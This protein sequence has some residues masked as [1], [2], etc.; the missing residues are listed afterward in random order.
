[1]AVTVSPPMGGKVEGPAAEALAGN[2]GPKKNSGSPATLGNTRT[3]ESGS[4]ISDFFKII[5]DLFA[6]KGNLNKNSGETPVSVSLGKKSPSA[7]NNSPE[8]KKTLLPAELVNKN[9]NLKETLVPPKGVGQGTP[10]EGVETFSPPI[11]KK[12]PVPASSDTASARETEEAKQK[13]VLSQAEE[14]AKKGSKDIPD[15]ANG[16]FVGALLQN[17][18]PKGIQRFQ[19]KNSKVDGDKD[20]PGIAKTESKKK[21]KRTD[22]LELEVYDLRTGASRSHPT[23]NGQVPGKESKEG[24]GKETDV[25]LKIQSPLSA[26]SQLSDTSSAVPS[27][28]LD[29]Q[30]ALA[31]E[32]RD[33]GNADI[34][35]HASMVLKDGDQGIIRLSL[36]PESLG[37]VKIRL[38]MAD[39]KI[40]GHILVQTPEALR[41]FESE[42]RS[43]E[44]AFRD[45]GFGGASLDV[46]V[47]P[48]GGGNQKGGQNPRESAE[49]FYSQRWAAKTYDGAAPSVYTP[50]VNPDRTSNVMSINLLA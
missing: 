34:V 6:G 10:G 7:E 13:K 26:N 44:Q 5:Q 21:D 1:V 3:Q 4:P 45:G 19:D 37:T 38:E 43:L 39:D 29:F 14:R 16:P 9:P 23:V 50:I 49:P 8:T 48:D 40:A 41:A 20:T 35:R 17:S 25:V 31:R 11:P 24:M 36:Q 2:R 46:S 12:T 15:T 28:P 33:S 22:R 42:I 47:S 30:N 27:S 18:P 32:L